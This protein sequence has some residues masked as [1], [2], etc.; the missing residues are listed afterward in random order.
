[1]K[2]LIETIINNAKI[3]GIEIKVDKSEMIAIAGFMGAM[4]KGMYTQPG[5]VDLVQVETIHLSDEHLNLNDPSPCALRVLLHELAH[6]TGYA[7]KFN[8][9]G[10]AGMH[11]RFKDEECF[12]SSNNYIRIYGG[13]KPEFEND[14]QNA[15]NYVLN[16]YINGKFGLKAA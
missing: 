14:I 8:R 15:F 12:K 5:F 16:Y 1:M 10:V 4:C 2:A 7:T 3:D 11:K 9:E 13:Y 6:S